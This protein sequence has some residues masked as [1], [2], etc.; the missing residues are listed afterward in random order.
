MMA[1]QAKDGR[2]DSDAKRR[3]YERITVQLEERFADT[4]DPTARMATAAAL[5]HHKMAD[6]FWTGFYLLRDG[7]LTVGP[8]QGTLACL[9]L[10]PHTGVCWACV[11]RE[12]TVVVPDVHA[13]LGH[14]ACDSRS[15][16]EIV[17]PLRDDEGRVIG[18]LD[19]DSTRYATFDA[20]DAE[21]LERIVA[22]IH[23]RF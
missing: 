4:G 15:N 13:F 1:E 6:F 23:E 8:Y 19:V 5:L 18:V 11:D 20:I 17:V 10:E 21:C 9:V 7:E 22:M 12:E 16:S 14:I 3:R 2:L